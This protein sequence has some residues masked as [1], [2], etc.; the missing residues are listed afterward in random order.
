MPRF[1]VIIPAFNAAATL[2][3]TLAS[4]HR[5]TCTDWEALVVDD[6][7]T[8]ATRAIAAAAGPR[9]RLLANPEKG[10]SAAR[11]HGAVQAQADILAFLDADDLWAPE[12]LARMA[13]AFADPATDAAFAGIEFFRHQPGDSRVTSTVP[14]GPLRIGT[15]IGEN[16]V[17][18][19]SN[20]C[21]R[22]AVFAASGGF[23]TKLVHNEDLE[24]LIRLAGRGARIIGLPE[25]LVW[26]R[27]SPAGLSADHAAMREG[28]AAALATARRFGV[29]PDARAEA[30]HLRHLARRAL[31]LDAGG[32]TALRLTAEGIA[33]SPAGFLSPARRGALTA[34]AALAAPALPRPVRRALFA[35]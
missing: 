9:V 2:P 26:Y 19:L 12:K 16:P 18:T 1:S 4:L 27:T 24:W 34:L 29:L 31:R 13:E 6:G 22:R 7:S 5:Q 33:T 10:P 3:A 32:L 28:R 23:D 21:V 35:R 25:R 11:N 14:P 15:L 30:I 20:L 8:D 17:C